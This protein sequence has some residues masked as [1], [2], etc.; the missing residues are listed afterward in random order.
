[1]IPKP[2][3]RKK[4]NKSVNKDIYARVMEKQPHCIIC[5]KTY[6]LERH[7][8]RHG[9]S[10]RKTY[11]GN[12]AVLCGPVIDKNSCH[13]KVHHNTKKWTPILIDMVNEIHGVDFPLIV[14]YKKLLEESNE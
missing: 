2:K 10:G 12:I 6:P 9:S 5:G 14:D 13:G 1:M 4:R 11:I 8:I 7:H 3:P